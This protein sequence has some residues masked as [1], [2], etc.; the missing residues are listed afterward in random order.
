MG[1]HALAK[2]G[3]VLVG[4][5]RMAAGEPVN[6]ESSHQHFVA[7]LAR[8]NSLFDFGQL[9]VNKNFTL[10]NRVL[11]VYEYYEGITDFICDQFDMVSGTVSFQE[12]EFIFQC[13]IGYCEDLKRTDHGILL[14]ILAYLPLPTL[15]HKVSRLNRKLYI[16]SGDVNLLRNYARARVEATRAA[17]KKIR[18]IEAPTYSI[19]NSS[20]PISF[21]PKSV[22]TNNTLS[23]RTLRSL[24]AE[25]TQ[26]YQ[27]S[28]SYRE[29]KMR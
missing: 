27:A 4:D 6:L 9:R 1:H 17:P 10:M 13:V 22:V 16:V 15:I 21:K 25:S 18:K 2:G 20:S 5:S 28:M 12:Y 19:S 8:V 14:R 3:R 29:Y 7:L 24:E 26:K 23:Y 11:Q